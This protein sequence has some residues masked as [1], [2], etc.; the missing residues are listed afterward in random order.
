VKALLTPAETDSARREVRGGHG[1][2]ESAVRCDAG[3]KQRRPCSAAPRRALGS[4]AVRPKEMHC[5]RSEI[6]SSTTACQQPQIERYP[7]RGELPVEADEVR[8]RAVSIVDRADEAHQAAVRRAD[9]T[10]HEVFRKCGRHRGEIRRRQRHE[11]EPLPLCT[12]RYSRC[13]GAPS[14]LHL[15]RGQPLHGET[16]VLDLFVRVPD[17]LR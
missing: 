1:L 4:S 3:R 2:E 15:H 17:A 13:S 14:V 10:G 11:A 8:D 12:F 5:A 9:A 7:R 16:G 6:A